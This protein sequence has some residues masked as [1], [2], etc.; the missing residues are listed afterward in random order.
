MLTA[1]F[2]FDCMQPVIPK[3]IGIGDHWGGYALVMQ[4]AE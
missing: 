4:D 1:R 3:G 2:V